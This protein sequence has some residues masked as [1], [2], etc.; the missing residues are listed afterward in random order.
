M[1]GDTPPINVSLP[2]VDEKHSALRNDGELSVVQ[3]N[4]RVAQ[5]SKKSKTPADFK[6]VKTTPFRKIDTAANE[7]PQAGALD[8]VDEKFSDIDNLGEDSEQDSDDPFTIYDAVA[9]RLGYDGLVKENQQPVAAADYLFRYKQDPAQD[10]SYEQ[11]SAHRYLQHR[12]PDSDLLKAIHAHASDFYGAH[13]DAQDSFE[14]MDETALIAMGILLEEAAAERLGKTGDLAFVEAARPGEVDSP[15][16]AGRRNKRQ[17]TRHGGG[18]KEERAF[19]A[20]SGSL[21]D[22]SSLSDPGQSSRRKRRRGGGTSESDIATENEED[23]TDED[24]SHNSEVESWISQTLLDAHGEPN[25]EYGTA[26]D[27]PIR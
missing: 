17:K 26:A 24:P 11:F 8:A 20:D 16:R 1:P 18:V 23:H 14:S 27:L 13:P 4:D 15:K 9:G 2:A 5:R 3:S 7:K 21:D 19:K 12:L 22:Q 10:A 25:G 6:P